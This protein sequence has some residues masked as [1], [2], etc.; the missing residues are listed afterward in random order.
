M[1]KID[2]KNINK[3]HKHLVFWTLTILII[4]ILGA[5]PHFIEILYARNLYPVIAVINRWIAVRFPFSIGDLVYFWGIAYFLYQILQLIIQIR[6]P[7]RQLL[8][9]ST[10]LLKTVWIFYLSWGF[11]YFREP[12][13][14]SLNLSTVQYTAEE[15]LEVTESLIERTNTLQLYLAGNDTLS[16]QIPYSI[17]NILRKT[18]AGYRE[19][20][21]YIN[22]KYHVPC[23]KTSLFSKQIS[24]MSVSG[25]LNPFTG[26]AQVN[27]LYPKV[28]LPDIASHEVAHQLG[29]TPEDEANFLGYLAATHHPDLYFNYSGNI[30][31]LYYFLVELRRYDKDVYRSYLKKL[32]KG[33][34]KNFNEARIFHQKYRF[35]VDFS[36]T[37]DSYLKLNNQQSGIRSYNEMVRLVIAYELG[38]TPNKL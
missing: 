34:L 22:V 37:Y 32:H 12:L 25:Y 20:E 23:I 2:F 8:K 10:F 3:F 4:K 9:I 33:V 29:F 1:K 35:P 21:N 19:I 36:T 24:Y 26:E 6:H 17:E 27:K 14:K 28:F 18:P 31:A 11:N 38:K 30:N 15:L 5:L 16:V 13:A 7:K